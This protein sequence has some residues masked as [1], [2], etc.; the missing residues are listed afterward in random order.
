M[1]EDQ[2][3]ARMDAE[4]AFDGAFMKVLE[5]RRDELMAAL[6]K[7]QTQDAEDAGY[8]SGELVRAVGE[9][10]TAYVVQRM[11]RRQ[12]Q[13][14]AREV[15]TTWW[16]EFFNAAMGAVMER[17]EADEGELVTD[18]ETIGEQTLGFAE[19]AEAFGGPCEVCGV[20]THYCLGG[21]SFCQEH[22]EAEYETQCAARRAKRRGETP[23]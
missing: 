4:D 5:A 14:T 22:I 10:A 16:A 8:I 11:A 18:P 15:A 23:T 20:H 13:P 6:D 3:D 1:S 2:A 19:S 7:E 21:R 12:Q 9:G 17:P